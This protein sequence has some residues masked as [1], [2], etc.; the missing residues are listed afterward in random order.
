MAAEL[1]KSIPTIYFFILF[2]KCGK[3]GGERK[4]EKYKKR[5]CLIEV[6]PY[7]DTF[8]RLY[9]HLYKVKTGYSYTPIV[10]IDGWM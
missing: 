3:R 2:V 10:S 4:K 5:K 8:Y 6:S 7:L 1:Q 9:M